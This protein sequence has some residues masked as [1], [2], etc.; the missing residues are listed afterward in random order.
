MIEKLLQESLL[1]SRR[2]EPIDW[3]KSCF[4]LKGRRQFAMIEIESSSIQIVL[5]G[6]PQE[7]AL[8]LLIFLIYIYNLNSSVKFSKTYNFADDTNMQTNKSL[9]VLAKQMNKDLSSLSYWL[10]ANKQCLNV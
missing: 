10:R 6:E 3:F 1:I 2:L 9:E 7:S 4:C 8:G 5:T